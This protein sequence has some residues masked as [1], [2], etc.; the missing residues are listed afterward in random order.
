M[1]NTRVQLGTGS[2]TPHFSNEKKNYCNQW[3]NTGII[4]NKTYYVRAMVERYGFTYMVG[5]DSICSPIEGIFVHYM[6]ERYEN[7][8]IGMLAGGYAYEQNNWDDHARDTPSGI[9]A[10]DPVRTKFG[11]RDVV[12]VLALEVNFDLVRGDRWA[13]KVNN[14]FTPVIFNH[15]IAFEYAF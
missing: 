9:D 12:P 6:F 10:P 4:V 7:W 2:I 8:E 11:G 13:V 5:N 3:N 1:A 14:M 15:S